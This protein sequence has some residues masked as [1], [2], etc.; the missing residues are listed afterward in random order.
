MTWTV[1]AYVLLFYMI[2]RIDNGIEQDPLNPNANGAAKYESCTRVADVFRT[3][4][5]I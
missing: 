4:G 1:L 5:L 2:M 3:H